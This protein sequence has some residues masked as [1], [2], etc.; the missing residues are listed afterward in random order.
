[1]VVSTFLKDIYLGSNF[2]RD[3][4]KSLMVV[5]HFPRDKCLDFANQIWKK[6]NL[7]MS[8]SLTKTLGN[9]FVRLPQGR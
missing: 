8:D 1:M 3:S 9:H 7:R 2:V 4:K 6:L 5:S